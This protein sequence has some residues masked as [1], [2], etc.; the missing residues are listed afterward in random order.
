MN[1]TIKVKLRAEGVFNYHNARERADLTDCGPIS[2]VGR[3]F[4]A[5]LRSF[6]IDQ[7]HHQRD[8]LIPVAILIS[9]TPEQHETLMRET[10]GSLEGTVAGIS[11]HAVRFHCQRIERDSPRASKKQQQLPNFI[12][13][14]D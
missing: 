7:E 11:R 10:D 2:A 8:D 3:T 1:D 6:E 5:L 13:H 9:L 14:G 12:T 4:N